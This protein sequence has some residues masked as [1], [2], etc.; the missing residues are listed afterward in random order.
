MSLTISIELVVAMAQSPF[1][2]Y[3]VDVKTKKL[4]AQSSTFSVLLIVVTTLLHDHLTAILNENTLGQRGVHLQLSS[5][6]V[7]HSFALHHRRWS[8]DVIAVAC[9]L[10]HKL[11]DEE[12]GT[13]RLLT[14]DI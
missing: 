10:T 14:N 6:Q 11:P 1:L 4:S 13:R 8:A 2:L 7:V 9:W 3:S 5:L 12:D